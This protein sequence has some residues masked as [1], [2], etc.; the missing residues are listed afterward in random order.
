[1]KAYIV[2]VLKTDFIT[3]NVKRFKVEKPFGYTF[4]PGQATEISIN[5]AD[6]ENDLRPFTFTSLPDADHLEFIIKIYTG[7]QGMTEKLLDVNEGDELIVHE[8]FGTIRYEGPGLFIAGGAGITPFIAILRH[9]FFNQLATQN[10]LTQS[11]LLFANRTEE[12]II[13]KSELQS[14]LSENYHDV[15]EVS[16]S[17]KP[18]KRID[19]ELLKQYIS[20]KTHYYYVCGP[21]KFTEAMVNSLTDLGVSKSQIILE[22]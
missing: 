4:I 1:M 3:H 9:L 11:R 5:R 21:D 17:G 20:P 10:Q 14:I 6:F 2:K 16:V 22:Q 13:L 19:K 12:D 18:G 8:V 15:I 7:H